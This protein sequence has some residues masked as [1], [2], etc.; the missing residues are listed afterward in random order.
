MVEL[1][2]ECVRVEGAEGV[3]RIFGPPVVGRKL[4]SPHVIWASNKLNSPKMTSSS[5]SCVSS[6]LAIDMRYSQR[7]HIKRERG[8]IIA[9]A[10]QPPLPLPLPLPSPSLPPPPLPP[11]PPTI[12]AFC[13]FFHVYF[14]FVFRGSIKDSRRITGLVTSIRYLPF[15]Q[16]GQEL[17]LPVTNSNYCH[18]SKPYF[19]VFF[20][21]ASN[22]TNASHV[23]HQHKLH[24]FRKL[25]YINV[26]ISSRHCLTIIVLIDKQQQKYP[27]FQFLTVHQLYLNNAMPCIM[28][29]DLSFLRSLDSQDSQVF[30]LG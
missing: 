18:Q 16:H 24:T 5:D 3:I 21:A 22:Q 25:L 19:P 2:R 30:V 10:A 6:R 1:V 17:Q 4:P 8:T 9:I 13:G 29:A 26:M 15:K 7:R 12:Q 20:F 14:I 23:Y 28:F 11:S 27:A